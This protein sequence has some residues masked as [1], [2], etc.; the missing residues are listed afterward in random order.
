[1]YLPVSKI[2]K[3]SRRRRSS[4]IA[5]GGNSEVESDQQINL[6]GCYSKY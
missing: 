6:C 1:M 3:S 4:L 5:G 2:S